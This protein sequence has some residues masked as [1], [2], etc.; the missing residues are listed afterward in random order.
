VLLSHTD[1]FGQLL[2]CDAAI[3]QCLPW[4]SHDANH[5]PITPSLITLSHFPHHIVNIQP[6]NLTLG[7]HRKT[8]SIKQKTDI[9]KEY[10]LLAFSK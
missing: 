10:R 4:V 8:H 7:H 1:C 2:L 6:P 9:P 3:F 5:K